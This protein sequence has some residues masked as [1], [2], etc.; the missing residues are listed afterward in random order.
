MDS[1]YLLIL[2][3]FLS[4]NA[5]SAKLESHLGEISEILTDAQTEQGYPGISLAILFEG[6]FYADQVGYADMA[7]ERIPDNETIFRIYSLTKGLTQILVWILENNNTLDIDTP[8]KNYLQSIPPH[9]QQITSQELLSHRSGIRHYR[10]NEEWLSLSQNH[11][12]SPRDAFS[13]FID[14]P[15]VVLDSSGQH[16]SSFGYVLLSGVLEAAAAEPF[17]AILDKYILEPTDTERTELDDPGNNITDNVTKFYEPSNEGYVEAPGIDNSCKFGGGAINSTPT[18]VAKI[19]SAYFSGNLTNEPSSQI[20]SSLPRRF[21][22]GG[23]GLGG[24]SA[25]VAYPQERLVVVIVSNARGGDLQP[26][27]E[28]ISQVILAN[29]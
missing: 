8:I 4:S 14:D 19:Y 16:Y 21:N 18:E 23:E 3:L 6:E 1:K 29:E 13:T 20:S 24:R 17:E 25:L 7:E 22:F 11:C 12:A 26:Y 9:I 5:L 10:S 27:A 15:L 2:V 28:E